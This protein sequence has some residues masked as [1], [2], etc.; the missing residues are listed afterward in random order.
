MPIRAL[1]TKLSRYWAAPRRAALTSAQV[2]CALCTGVGRGGATIA[3]GPV[4]VVMASPTLHDDA[5]DRPAPHQGGHE[6]EDDDPHQLHTD[7]PERVNT[8]QGADV[9]AG[10]HVR[11]RLER[12]HLHDGPQRTGER[13][14]RDQRPGQEACL[15]Y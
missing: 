9:D 10:R 2:T 3:V 1:I 8:A 6:P 13:A 5:P 14:D 7:P 15:L 11:R 4:V 12:Q